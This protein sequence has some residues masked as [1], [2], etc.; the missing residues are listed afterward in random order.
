MWLLLYVDDVIVMGK[1]L[2]EICIVK[3][4]LSELL[5]MKDLG[6][7]GSFLGVSFTQDEGGAWLS[8]NYYCE[9]ILQRFGMTSYKPVSTPACIDIETIEVSGP[10]DASRYYEIVG[11][12]LFLS[13]RTRPDIA[14]AV[15]LISRHN[16]NPTDANMISSKRVL[17]YLRGTT[18][19]ALR[20]EKSGE[21]LQAFSDA[22]WA[23][24]RKDRKSTSGVLLQ[25]GGTSVV[26]KSG[27]QSC[28]ALSS[29]ES[30]HI[31]LS[32]AC[33]EIIWMRALLTDL[34]EGEVVS[35]APPTNVFEDNQITIG[36]GTSGVRNTK[37]VAVRKNF[38]REQVQNGV[39]KLVY[40]PTDKMVADVLTKPLLRIKFEFHREGLGVRDPMPN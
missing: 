13:T 24:D 14:G 2:S 22:D 23:G 4:E 33:K 31:A 5:E 28:N 8:Q 11:S 17:R 25:V 20:L 26:W 9:Q 7:L 34:T 40:L 37:H 19:F 6:E 21:E 35:R 32:E 30:E 10:C 36:W 27:K 38:V 12:L 15:N 29:T 1:E 18:R 16:A 3:R 39:V